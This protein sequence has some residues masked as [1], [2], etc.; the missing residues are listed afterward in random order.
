MTTRRIIAPSPA[1]EV[2][3]HHN[4]S[5]FTFLIIIL[6]LQKNK[7]PYILICA[8]ALSGYIGNARLI[9]MSGT[10][11]LGEDS[12]TNKQRPLVTLPYPW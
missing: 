6:R 2:R 12:H 4:P 7:S 1:V 3:G 9:S 8:P 10:G 11:G 5:P